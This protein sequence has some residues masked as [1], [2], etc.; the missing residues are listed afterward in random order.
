M[1]SK[2]LLKC[3][4]EEF[5]FKGHYGDGTTQKFSIEWEL[6]KVNLS[7]RKGN[8]VGFRALALRQSK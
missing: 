4:L 7:T 8:K 1:C 6:K 5:S 2:H 3:T